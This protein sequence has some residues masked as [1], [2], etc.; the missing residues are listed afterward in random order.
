MTWWDHRGSAEWLSYTFPEPRKLSECAV[1][2]FDDTGIGACRVPAEWRLLWRDG[3]E[4]RPVKLKDGAYGTDRDRFN[5]VA[6]EPVTA[7][8]VRLE[9]KLRPGY[10]GGVL[11][12]AVR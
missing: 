9:V 4:W 6:F 2:W 5:K 8:E 3:Q 7:R 10:S 1:Y 11:R 12:W